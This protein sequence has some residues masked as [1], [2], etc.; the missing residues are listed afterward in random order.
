MAALMR[1][2][3]LTLSAAG[4]AWTQAGYALLLA[5]LHRTRA[6]PVDAEPQTPKVSLVVAAYAEEAVIAAKVRNALALDWPRDRLE[7]IVAVDGGADAGADATAAEAMSAGADVV[8]ALPRGGKVRAQDEAVRR[9]SGELLAFSDANSMWEPAALRALAA[10]FAD[11]EVGYACGQVT[12]L[13][14]TGTNQEGLYW[15]YEMWLRARESELQSVTAGNGA[16]YAV[17]PQAYFEGDPRVSHDLAFPF[18]LVKRGW[19][20][21][22]APEARAVEKM[23]PSV[24]GEWRR[25]RRMMAHAWPAI[26]TGGLADPRG[27][28][29]LYALMIASHRLLRYASPLLHVVL[30]LSSRRR[31]LAAQL[32]LLAAAAVPVRARPFLIAR[33]YVLTTASIGFGLWDWLRHGTEAS[34]DHA[35]GTR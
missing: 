19:R 27:Y 2:L 3:A 16:I 15:R 25:K 7:L 28:P 9:A 32:A 26:A 33:Y 30:L 24:E 20:C 11:P 12:F 6:K 34:W 17:R 35:E 4:L 14:A 13:N 1:R 31:L 29:P 18:A 5:L 21:V 8:L 22:Y 23:V 10:P